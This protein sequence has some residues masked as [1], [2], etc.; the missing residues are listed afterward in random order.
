MVEKDEQHRTRRDSV[1]EEAAESQPAVSAD[2]ET[3]KKG[4]APKATTASPFTSVDLC[5]LDALP[6]SNHVC[7]CVSIHTHKHTYR[8]V[9][10]IG[11]TSNALTHLQKVFLCFV[12]THFLL[13][14]AV[15][16]IKIIKNKTT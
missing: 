13:L 1:H 3:S 10:T 8:V 12:N 5:S 7:L 9:R 15:K 6:Y 4:E 2:G 11:R 16:N 14:D